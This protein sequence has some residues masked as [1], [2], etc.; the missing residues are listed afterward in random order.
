MPVDAKKCE[1]PRSA[2]LAELREVLMSF[3]VKRILKDIGELPKFRFPEHM[4][5]SGHV[6]RD[7]WGQIAAKCI[8]RLESRSWQEKWGC[9][10]GV[11]ST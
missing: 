10:P 4:K 3:D 7:G 6:A 1:G 8:H 9:R 11:R 5:R 2:F